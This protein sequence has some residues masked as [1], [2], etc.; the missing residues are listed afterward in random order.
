MALSTGDLRAIVAEWEQ[1]TGDSR[2]Q[3]SI[4]VRH[5]PVAPELKTGDGQISA[6]IAARLHYQVQV[7]RDGALVFDERVPHKAE[8]LRACLAVLASAIAGP[9]QSS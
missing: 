6:R 7:R 8:M 9:E 3:L 5:D 1:S 4:E 2:F